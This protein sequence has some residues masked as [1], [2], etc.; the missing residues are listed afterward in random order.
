MNNYIAPNGT[1]R[2]NSYMFDSESFI[3]KNK[4]ENKKADEMSLQHFENVLKNKRMR[5]L[6]HDERA[7]LF[8]QYKS[9]NDERV[10]NKLYHF[11]LPVISKIAEKYQKENTQFSLADLISVG[12]KQLPVIFRGIDATRST[13]DQNEYIKDSMYRAIARYVR[14]ENKYA[15]NFIQAEQ[16]FIEDQGY[17]DIKRKGSP[18]YDVVDPHT[19]EK[20]DFLELREYIFGLIAGYPEFLKPHQFLRKIKKD[21]ID[22]FMQY[23]FN[24][25][26]P[27]KE[28]KRG[29]RSV[30][31]Q[32]DIAKKFGVSGSHIS[33][34]LDDVRR[35]IKI[36]LIYGNNETSANPEVLAKISNRKLPHQ[37]ASR[38]RLGLR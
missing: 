38:K 17:Q 13:K 14:D 28:D 36:R 31:T 1:Y 12:A 34:I 18:A 25:L 3:D 4:A 35:K 2:Y 33:K 32:D 7:K 37:I 6:S 15:K 11:C 16:G 21:D 8:D 29:K 20:Q 9:T 5:P 27:D 22:I 26:F 23:F 30:V 24:D 19:Y 10:F